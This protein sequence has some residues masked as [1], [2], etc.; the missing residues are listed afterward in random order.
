MYAGEVNFVTPQ[1]MALDI[2]TISKN[3]PDTTLVFALVRFCGIETAMV[4]PSVSKILIELKIV[5]RSFR[6][7]KLHQ[8]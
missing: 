6:S 8:V 2:N 1:N 4:V 3:I 7:S 5:S